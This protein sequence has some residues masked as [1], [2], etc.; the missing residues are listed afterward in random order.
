MGVGQARLLLLPLFSYKIGFELNDGV[1]ERRILVCEIKVKKLSFSDVIH[2]M[3]LLKN[4]LIFLR[5][6]ETNNQKFRLRF[7]MQS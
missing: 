3:A 4:H 1:R 6:T 2:C 7:S 5:E